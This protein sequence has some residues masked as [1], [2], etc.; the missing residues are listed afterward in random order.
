MKKRNIFTAALFVL[1]PVISL[2]LGMW[3]VGLVIIP[4][5]AIATNDFD[6]AIA[7]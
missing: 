5:L 1:A 6:V 4:L 3:L 2:A 7:H